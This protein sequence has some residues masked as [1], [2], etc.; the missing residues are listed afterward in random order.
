MN[1]TTADLIWNSSISVWLKADLDILVERTGRNG[2]RPILKNGNPRDILQ[3]LMDKRY[4]IYENAD[5]VVESTSEEVGKTLEVL[6]KTLAD[7]L[8]STG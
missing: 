8:E 7:H 3:G 5:I 1:E 2:K 4:P 6:L